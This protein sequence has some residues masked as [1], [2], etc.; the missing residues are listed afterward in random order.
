MSKHLKFSLREWL[1]MAYRDESMCPSP[2]TL[3]QAV[4]GDLPD[5]RV[6]ELRHHMASCPTCAAEHDLARLFEEPAAEEVTLE[7]E[8]IVSQLAL[9]S[10][11]RVAAAVDTSPASVDISAAGASTLDGG[12]SPVSAGR[13]DGERASFLGRLAVAPVWSYAAAALLVLAFGISFQML[14][15]PAPSL[16]APT[17]ST[18]RGGWVEAL[19]PLGDA[20]WPSAQFR[21]APVAGAAGF[22]VTLAGVDEA[23]LWEQT[24][25]ESPATLPDEIRSLLH[26]RV[27]YLW[28]IEAFDEQGATIALSDW[29]RMRLVPPGD[30]PGKD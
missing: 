26:P 2:R 21:W 20:V 25:G 16:P 23:V 24:V 17:A 14:Q 19:S 9:R 1:R 7:V 10:P 3:H 28:K 6:A 27:V 4:A 5:G 29:V 30:S 11:V 12:A 13:P 8:A 15:S 22:R 18:Q